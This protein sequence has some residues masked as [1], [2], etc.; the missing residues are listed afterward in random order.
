[1]TVDLDKRVLARIKSDT[2]EVVGNLLDLPLNV[3][4]EHLTLM[5]NSL[6][7]QVCNCY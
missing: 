3:T 7:Q 4:V 6:L 1:M 5:C 2:G